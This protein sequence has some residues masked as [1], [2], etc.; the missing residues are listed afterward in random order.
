MALFIHGVHLYVMGL[1]AHVHV[2][3]T[4]TRHT[5]TCMHVCCMASGG[6]HREPA[7]SVIAQLWEYLLTATACV[8]ALVS[9][10]R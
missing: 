9:F 1:C 10:K 8:T 3:V 5:C 7:A 4:A 2:H 6:K